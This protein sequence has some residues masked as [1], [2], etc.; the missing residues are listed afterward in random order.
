MFKKDLLYA[1][2]HTHSLNSHDGT[3]A[4][5]NM[6][7]AQIENGAFAVAV[8]DHIDLMVFESQ[9]GFS[10]VKASFEEVG[11]LKGKYKDS[12]KVLSGVEMSDGFLN[13]ELYD[14]VVR[15]CD[16]DVIVGSTHFARYKRYSKTYYSKIDFR[17]LGDNEIY[18]Y[19]DAYFDDVLE[20]AEQFD[21]DILAHLTCPLRYI[22]GIYKREVDLSRFENKTD[23]ILKTIIK[24]EI[25]LEVNTSTVDLLGDFMPGE[26]IIR[27][28]YNLGGRLIT[29]GSDAHV[30]EKASTN[31]EK[32]AELLLD[33]GFKN[34][35]YYEKRVPV[36]YEIKKRR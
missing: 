32:A 24:R 17:E 33:I 1:D 16:Y 30:L 3:C 26:D 28:Y 10:P 2:M 29:L 25:A 35:Y 9:G 13:P 19:L 34:L 8:T 11:R 12:F 27:R 22:C 5:E 23:N 21:F 4:I 31:F 20:T 14:K 18:G 6:C 36:A 15:L 7:S